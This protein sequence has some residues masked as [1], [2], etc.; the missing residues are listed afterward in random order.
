MR[1][2]PKLLVIGLLSLIL[3]IRSV[4]YQKEV[5]NVNWKFSNA[6]NS[7]KM[8]ISA[9]TSVEFISEDYDSSYD[10]DFGDPFDFRIKE[11]LIPRNN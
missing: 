2:T 10:Y 11:L 8:N 6:K 3:E 1:L 7:I 4:N 5:D 9:E